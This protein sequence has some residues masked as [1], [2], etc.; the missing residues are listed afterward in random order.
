MPASRGRG[1]LFQREPYDSAQRILLNRAAPVTGVRSIAATTTKFPRVSM[2]ALYGE[3]PEFATI[4]AF[5][6][7]TR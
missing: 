5:G 4:S 7:L 1:E 6:G 3:G 2:P